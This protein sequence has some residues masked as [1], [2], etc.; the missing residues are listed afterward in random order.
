MKRLLDAFRAIS[1][2]GRAWKEV[3][4]DRLKAVLGAP[5]PPTLLDIRPSHQYAA[6]H[7]PGALN[8]PLDRGGTE[9]GGF[10]G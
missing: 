4:A 8:V 3:S 7:L 9:C 10:F 2:R 5:S 6:G 1:R